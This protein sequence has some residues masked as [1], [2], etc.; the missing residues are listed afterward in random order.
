MPALRASRP[1]LVETLKDD[2]AGSAGSR[3]TLL[4]NGLV[5]AQVALSLVLLIA[6]GLLL[7]SLDRARAADPGFDP[8]N[9]LVAGIDLM[10]N[11]YDAARGRLAIVQMTDRIAALPG[12]TAV[13]MVSPPAARARRHQFLPVRR[14]R[15]CARQER[16]NGLISPTSS[17]RTTSTR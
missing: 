13:S 6:A 14:G 5:V 3:R 1:D 17:G 4:R 7:K 2:S 15:L 16:R 10:P 8:R 12:V 11:G 9:V